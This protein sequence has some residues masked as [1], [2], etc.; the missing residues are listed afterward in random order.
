MVEPTVSRMDTV[1]VLVS[2]RCGRAE[3]F[4]GAGRSIAE[5]RRQG[6][7]RRRRMKVATRCVPCLTAWIVAA[8]V[9]Y[10]RRQLREAGRRLFRKRQNQF[11][12]A[13]VEAVV[14]ALL[15]VIKEQKVRK[16]DS[17]ISLLVGYAASLHGTCHYPVLRLHRKRSAS[18]FA[19]FSTRA[20][21]RH[22]RPQRRRAPPRPAAEGPWLAAEAFRTGWSTQKPCADQ[23]KVGKPVDAIRYGALSRLKSSDGA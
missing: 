1:I 11:V 13:V 4:T 14:L 17:G 15:A 6:A 8:A 22:P 3:V 12:P 23:P 2:S 16:A 19:E 18:A 5:R 7:D 20:I 9:V 10:W 21:D